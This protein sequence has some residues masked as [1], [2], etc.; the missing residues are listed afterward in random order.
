MRFTCTVAEFR[1]A[2]DAARRAVVA[3]PPMI[4]Y[5]ALLV[6]VKGAKLYVTGSDSETTVT[7]V[8]PLSGEREDGSVLIGPK[9]LAAWLSR[10]ADSGAVTVWVAD[11]GDLHCD[12]GASPYTFRPMTASYPE[13]STKLSGLPELHGDTARLVRALGAVRH[14]AAGAVRI[15]SVGETL[16][17]TATDNFRLAQVVVD[18]CGFGDREG[19]LG[20]AAAD[21]LVRHVP[22]THLGIDANGRELR[23]RNEHVRITARLEATPF[24]PVE[25]VL[26]EQPPRSATVGVAELRGALDRLVPLAGRTPAELTVSAGELTISVTNTELGSGSETVPAVGATEEFRCGVDAAYLRDAV[27]AQVGDELTIG[28]STPR[29]ALRVRSA[30]D[31]GVDCLLMPV[32]LG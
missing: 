29:Q 32:M 27:G 12:A 7:S 20:L 21:T 22:L 8:V 15:R 30:A 24:P 25:G 10:L 16:T 2:I 1:N 26:A 6:R 23:A 4:A 14:A 13:P 28:W 9:A 3:N 11:D 19:V 18:G 5:S 31:I 17:L